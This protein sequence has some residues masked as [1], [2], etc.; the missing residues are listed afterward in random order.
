MK[1]Q[2]VRRETSDQGTFGQLTLDGFH[3]SWATAELPWRKN[4]PEL[5]CIPTGLYTCRTR[6]SWRFLST[7][8]EVQGVPGRSSILIHKGNYAG[9]K[10]KGYKTDVEGCILL[11]TFK[12]MLYADDGK[13]QQ[14]VVNS[15][16]ALS[17]FMAASNN[18][19]LELTI[20]E[21][22]SKEG[23]A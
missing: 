13:A 19:P 3:Q 11:G 5:S 22:F 4:K 6:W 1:A 15:R 17:L 20:S 10:T 12:G 18:E 9:D 16:I 2:L 7:L 8:Y 21:D 23:V 14:A